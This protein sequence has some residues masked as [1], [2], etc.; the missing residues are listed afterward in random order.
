MDNDWR[1]LKLAGISLAGAVFVAPVVA[2]AVRNGNTT[3]LLRSLGA[4]AAG[5]GVL[6]GTALRRLGYVGHV[7]DG[8][9]AA[10]GGL[11]TA[12]VFVGGPTEMVSF[13]GFCVVYG[14][15]N[16]S[17]AFVPRLPRR[18]VAATA[19]VLG[20][21]VV[22]ATVGTVGVSVTSPLHIPGGVVGVVLFIV[23]IVG[24][25]QPERL[26][27]TSNDHESE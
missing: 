27:D 6:G 19:A 12:A 23:G 16:A 5:L 7:G 3:T 21:G 18:L 20:A 26:P 1:R 17:L 22:A 13:G 14:V 9:L 8:S 2:S 10:A 11:A 25:V 24:I 4:V 15:A